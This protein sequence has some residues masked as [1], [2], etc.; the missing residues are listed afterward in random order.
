MATTVTTAVNHCCWCGEPCGDH[1]REHGGHGPAASAVLPRGCSTT[2]LL[3]EHP[4]FLNAKVH[5][6]KCNVLNRP[7]T[8]LRPLPAQILGL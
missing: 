3:V 7:A 8:I 5:Y 6:R 1:R 4:N 2:A